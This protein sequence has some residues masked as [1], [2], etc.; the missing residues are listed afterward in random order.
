MVGK[1]VEDQMTN[2]IDVNEIRYSLNCKTYA[3]IESS[4]GDIYDLCDAYESLQKENEELKAR[5]EWRPIHESY[6]GKNYLL[7]VPEYEGLF[8]GKCIGCRHEHEMYHIPVE[9]DLKNIQSPIVEYPTHFLEIPNPPKNKG[10][11]YE[12]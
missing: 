1:I 5:S 12:Y 10:S 7:F 11:S 3:A 9:G 4:L 2:K 6:C 8:F